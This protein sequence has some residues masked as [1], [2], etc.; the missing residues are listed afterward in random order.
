[1]G[2]FEIKPLLIMILPCQYIPNRI[3]CIIPIRNQRKDAEVPDSAE[4]PCS[5]GSDAH[6]PLL[7]D[8]WEMPGEGRVRPLTLNPKPLTLRP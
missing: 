3:V 5:A 8:D 4:S 2:G 6:L 7:G 1:M